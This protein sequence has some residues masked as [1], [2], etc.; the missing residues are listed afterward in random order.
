MPVLVSSFICISARGGAYHVSGSLGFF[1]SNSH[2]KSAV[3]FTCSFSTAFLIITYPLYFQNFQSS[4]DKTL[5]G[6]PLL[7]SLNLILLLFAVDGL[8][9][10]SLC[11]FIVP[12]D[13]VA[14][15]VC[16]S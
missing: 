15:I 10:I 7:R 11:A 4:S 8:P 2:K 5:S 12:G 13:I 1:S 3:L 6:S 14:A 9:G 16:C